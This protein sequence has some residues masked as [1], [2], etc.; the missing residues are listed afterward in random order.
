MSF[1]TLKQ[2]IID[3]R[4]NLILI[5]PILLQTLVSM[6]IGA[7]FLLLGVHL[8]TATI[9]M[10]FTLGP[11]IVAAAMQPSAWVIGLIL[12]GVATLLTVVTNSWFQAGYFAMNH[13]VAHKRKTRWNDFMPGVRKHFRS[14]LVFSLLVT[15][16]WLVLLLP[17]IVA[18]LLYFVSKL[19]AVV[20]FLI[21]LPLFIAG[22]LLIWVTLLFGPPL[23]VDKKLSGLETIKQSWKFTWSNFIL[24][25]KTIGVM[26]LVG[27]GVGV[28]FSIIQLPLQL[29]SDK[30]LVFTVLYY[31][32]EIIR[33]IVQFLV[34]VLL[35][36]FLFNMYKK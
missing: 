8:I 9:G 4:A 36:V 15:L 17:V 7:I 11:Q 33:V 23:L 20:L 12:L 19:A 1:S 26:L 6:A 25:L 35:T 13:R 5:V 30:Y 14:V 2:S 18:I 21:W 29:L 32:I 16:I 28:C 3:F 22:A 27:L 24:V 34:S 10:P 31:G